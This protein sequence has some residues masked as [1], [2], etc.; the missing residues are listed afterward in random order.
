M[1]QD[2]FLAAIRRTELLIDVFQAAC[3]VISSGQMK[4][5]SR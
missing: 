3:E 2:F 5:G 1:Y 4:F